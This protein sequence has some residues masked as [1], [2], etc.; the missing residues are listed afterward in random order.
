MS[1]HPLDNEFDLSKSPYDE[2]YVSDVTIPD[3]VELR[4]LDLVIDLALKQYKEN[5]DDMSLLEPKNKLKLMELNRDLLNIVKDARYKKD[6]L[7]LK[8]E[9][10]K[11]KKKQESEGDESEGISRAELAKKAAKLRAVK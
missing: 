11:P 2:N 9:G 3:D 6:V 7:T 1:R 8:R 5:S 10:T 4:D